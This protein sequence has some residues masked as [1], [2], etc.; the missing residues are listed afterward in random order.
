[1]GF[2]VTTFASPYGLPA[3]GRCETSQSGSR[4]TFSSLKINLAGT[5]HLQILHPIWVDTAVI[6]LKNELSL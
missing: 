4:M 1:V 2:G 3:S 6:L 5:L